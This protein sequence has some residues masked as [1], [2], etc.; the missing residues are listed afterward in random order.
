MD[1]ESWLGLGIAIICLALLAFITVAEI[2][3]ANT[4]K[5]NVKH[6][7]EISEKQLKKVERFIQS[8]S[9]IFPSLVTS[10]YIA[11]IGFIVASLL[12]GI[13]WYGVNWSV[14]II[15]AVTV[16]VITTFIELSAR[17]IA[18]RDP[19]KI[20]L[21]LATPSLGIAIISS[22][23]VVIVKLFIGI[24]LKIFG[25]KN[26][27]LMVRD[28]MSE[29][30]M[31]VDFSNQQGPLEEDEKEMIR[32][33]VGLDETTTREIMVPRID[34]VA[35]EKDSSINDLIAL[36]IKKG[37][38][39]IPVYE[40]TID[41]ITGVVY[42]KDLLTVLINGKLDTKIMD[43]VR[44]VHFVPETKK[45]DQ[46][47]HEF[48]QKRVHIAIVVDEYGGTA[49][50]VTIEDLLEEIVGEIVD[51]YDR[52]EPTI[53][54][55]SDVEMIM[56]AKVS[57]DEVN[58]LFG[59][60]LEGDDFDTIGGFVFSKL[61]RIPNIGDEIEDSGIKI[62]ILATSGRR[63]KDVRVIKINVTNEAKEEEK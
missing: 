52:E 46:L 27:Q 25:M 12:L 14:I 15:T 60:H 35:V 37:F 7:S 57:I 20:A 49:G 43:I 59:S 42:A 51:E 39:R 2:A 55:I 13:R 41:N 48:Q 6:P 56:N 45:I 10:K 5:N 8:Q 53:K 11:L 24:V 31:L 50:L 34:I 61:G 62:S 40:D 44:T 58:E 47:L 19:R 17:N 54:K 28:E 22:P 33:V 38:S 30:G 23:L 4:R 18:V 32:G 29:L 21:F 36:I 9:I 63:V 1:T 3:F 16:I 26:I